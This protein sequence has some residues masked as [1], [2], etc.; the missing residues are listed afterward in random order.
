MAELFV[1]E[2]NLP[3]SLFNQFAGSA[4][5]KRRMVGPRVENAV[6][7]ENVVVGDI[8]AIDNPIESGL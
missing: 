4:G 3:V 6:A 8:I 7:F 1:C 2:V 5:G